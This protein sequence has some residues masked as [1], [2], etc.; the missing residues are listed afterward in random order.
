MKGM[1]DLG[2]D[3]V[4]IG[5]RALG[6]VHKQRATRG[7]HLVQVFHFVQHR[8]PPKLLFFFFAESAL[9]LQNIHLF[10]VL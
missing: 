10:P 8:F 3:I 7:V 1:I 5:R 9:L 2:Y 6:N 4:K